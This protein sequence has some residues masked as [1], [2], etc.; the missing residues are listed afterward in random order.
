MKGPA[1]VAVEG[2]AEQFCKRA[3]QM[4]EAGRCLGKLN[5]EATVIWAVGL[6]S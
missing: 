1:S 5:V 2:V 6:M 4:E 3:V